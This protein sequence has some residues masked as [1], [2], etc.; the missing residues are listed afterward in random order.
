MYV[1][2]L[3][4]WLISSSTQQ[5]DTAGQSDY[6]ITVYLDFFF[7]YLEMVVMVSQCRGGSIMRGKQT[8]IKKKLNICVTKEEKL[9]I[10]GCC[11]TYQTFH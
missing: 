11:L 1:C 10:I 9:S 2:T 3:C 7:L 8:Y 6:N 4:L 5:K